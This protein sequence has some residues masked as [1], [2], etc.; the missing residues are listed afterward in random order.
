MEDCSERIKEEREVRAGRKMGSYMSFLC[1]AYHERSLLI[2]VEMEV[3]EFLQFWEH[4]THE[5]I[6]KEFEMSEYRL[7][8]DQGYGIQNYRRLPSFLVPNSGQ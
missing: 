2:Y 6:W 3:D 7:H 4:I 5:L 1:F 8:R